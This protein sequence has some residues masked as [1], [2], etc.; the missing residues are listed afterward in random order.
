M[1][2]ISG[3]DYGNSKEIEENECELIQKVGVIKEEQKVSE[4]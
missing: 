3:Q 4:N 1:T 2:L